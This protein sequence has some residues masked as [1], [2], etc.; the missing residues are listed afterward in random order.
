MKLGMSLLGLFCSLLLTSCTSNKLPKI[1]DPEA[2][3]KDCA[4][5]YQQ[6]PSETKTNRLGREYFIYGR[7]VSKGKWTP[8]ISALKPLQVVKDKCG[9]R[10][11]IQVRK[12]WFVGYYVFFD[13]TTATPTRIILKNTEVKGIYE[14]EE[15]MASLTS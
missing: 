6:Y 10:I 9:I 2:L 1:T 15:P 7:L 3:R 8:A 11:Y 12:E 4:A 14:F 5:L 13:Q